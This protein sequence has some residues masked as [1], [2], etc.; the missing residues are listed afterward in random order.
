[1]RESPIVR[2]LSF[3][4]VVALGFVALAWSEAAPPKHVPSGQTATLLGDGRVLVA[5]G[6]DARDEAEV[7][8]PHRAAFASVAKMLAPRIHHTATL[9]LSGKVLVA[10]GDN[11]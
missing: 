5:G 4:L 1:M 7:F 10:G 11:G 3:G 8:E 6:N 9:L 2:A